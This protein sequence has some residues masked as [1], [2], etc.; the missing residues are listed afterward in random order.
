LVLRTKHGT[1]GLAAF[2]GV[3]RELGPPTDLG[4]RLGT[5][6]LNA[7]DATT[8]LPADEAAALRSWLAE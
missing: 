5:A 2:V 6:L 1:A 3:A 7:K 4:R 8:A